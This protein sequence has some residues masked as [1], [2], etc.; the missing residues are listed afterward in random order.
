MK[1]EVLGSPHDPDIARRFIAEI[2]T[3]HVVDDNLLSIY[4]ILKFFHESDKHEYLNRIGDSYRKSGKPYLAA[5]CFLES[6]RRHPA[7]PETYRKYEEIQDHL[8]PVPF[9]NA[10]PQETLVSVIMG[11]CNRGADIIES[12]ES[13][14]GQT[15]Q[16]FELIVVNDG[17][18]SDVENLLRARNSPKI[19]YFKL[20]KNMGHAAALNEGIRKSQGR[21][22]AYLDDDD[23]YYPNHLERM[24]KAFREGDARFAYSNTKMVS[25]VM[26]EGRFRPEGIKGCWDVEYDKNKLIA[27]NFIANL[28]VLHD[29]SV[30]SEVGLFVEELRVVMDWE[31]WLR[32]SLK[33]DLTHVD[34]YTGEYRFKK[35]NVTATN[36]LLIDFY[37]EL[38]RNYYTYYKGLV[39]KHDC[40]LRQGNTTAA[41]A[42]YSEI[43]DRYA[44][45]FKSPDS[46]EEL[47]RLSAYYHD[48]GFSHTIAVDYF[49]LNTRRYLRYV[50]GSGRYDL[51][52]PVSRMIPR[53]V[54]NAVRLRLDRSSRKRDLP[55]R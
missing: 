43:R 51:L 16:D 26:A 55:E 12:V 50:G 32:T 31:M 6:V 33:F 53:K 54:V 42:I 46:S 3:H 35:G 30:F 39:A 10:T 24:L 52:L 45:Y 19:K 5:L 2:D 15:E 21:Y 1:E 18:D 13:V 23:V 47:F 41:R 9:R 40:L 38:V 4:L 11:T 37:T 20:P 22:I 25:G 36:R 14:L 34:A 17:G 49:H 29:R 8:Q 48:K 44:D 28:S 27:D 7:D